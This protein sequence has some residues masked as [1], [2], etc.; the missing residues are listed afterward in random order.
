MVHEI[1]QEMASMSPEAYTEEQTKVSAAL[2][3]CKGAVKAGE[4]LA[5]ETMHELLRR[6]ADVHNPFACPHGRP[7]IV[8]INQAEMERRF[9]RR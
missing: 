9:L 8:E 2:V 1:V 4:R 6:L 5:P 3:A 7:I